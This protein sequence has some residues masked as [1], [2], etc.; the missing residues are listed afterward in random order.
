MGYAGSNIEWQRDVPAIDTN[1]A[2]VLD[3]EDLFYKA[4]GNRSDIMALQALLDA[5]A[6][7]EK[8]A[9]DSRWPVIS[10]FGSY[11]QYGADNPEP[12]N[13]LGNWD[14]GWEDNY[15]VGVQ[16]SLPLFDSGLRSGQIRSAHAQYLKQQAR[17]DALMLEVRR[18]I[19]SAIA[20][21]ESAR[22]RVESL[23]E[24]ASEAGLAFENEQKKYD[25][26]KSTINNLLDA[27]SA[28]LYAESG[29]SEAV[30]ELQIAYANLRL[31]TGESMNEKE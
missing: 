16:L 26:G 7:T 24:S 3:E 20:E 18:Q 13:A 27:E 6:A 29:L 21:I 5:G 31:V 9:R 1:V 22:A 25:N 28:R 23:Q 30:H 11:G 15:L 8:S 12:G 10:A 2:E 19:R 4:A 14:Q 17:Y